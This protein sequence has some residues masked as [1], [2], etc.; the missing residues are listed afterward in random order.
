MDPAKGSPNQYAEVLALIDALS[1]TLSASDPAA[2]ATRKHL[3]E[4][5]EQLSFA[6]ET[7]GET[8]Q[9][10]AYYVR[11]FP[12]SKASTLT[13][14][15]CKTAYADNGR[16]HRQQASTFSHLGGKHCTRDRERAGAKE[17]R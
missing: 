17:W 3:K 9:R 8:V 7:P 10:V 2:P 11:S 5:V 14:N 13:N 16:S 1:K 4:T 15:L 6:L 12:N